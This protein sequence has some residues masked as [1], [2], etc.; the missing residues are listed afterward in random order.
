[1]VSG[2]GCVL[3]AIFTGAIGLCVACSTSEPGHKVEIAPAAEEPAVRPSVAPPAEETTEQK[4]AKHR[5][6]VESA[7][8]DTKA[9]IA[10]KQKCS[11]LEPDNDAWRAISAAWSQLKQVD[12]SDSEYAAAKKLAKQLE[13]CRKKS[14][15]ECIRIQIKL[16]GPKGH[17]VTPQERCDEVMRETWELGAELT[18]P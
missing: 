6:V 12:A 10:S 4:A 8:A 3:G 11:S 13:A 18:L 15:A 16:T 9:V 17:N 14:R 1:M 2:A 5:A 7:I